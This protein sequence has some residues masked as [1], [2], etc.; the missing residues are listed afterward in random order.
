MLIQKELL[1][2]KLGVALLLAR[3]AQARTSFN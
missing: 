3:G 2:T 1:I